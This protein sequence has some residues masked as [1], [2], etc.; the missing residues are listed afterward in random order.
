MTPYQRAV[1]NFRRQYWQRLL[2][3]HGS[4]RAAAHAAGLKRTSAYTTLQRLG[5][6][7]PSLPHSGRWDQSTY[8]ES[9]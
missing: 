4:V 5:I 6:P 8:Q 9:P 7:R 2:R 3:Q 1:A